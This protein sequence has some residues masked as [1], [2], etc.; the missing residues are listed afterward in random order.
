MLDVL[1]VLTKQV[2]VLNAFLDIIFFMISAVP[3]QK[4]FYKIMHVKL[5]VM[6]ITSMILE[7]ANNVF[8]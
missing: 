2:Y 1:P 5:S 6:I 8:N 7:F 4:Q 3:Q